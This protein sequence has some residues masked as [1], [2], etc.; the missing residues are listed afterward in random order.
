MKI[1]SVLFIKDLGDSFSSS[2]L[3]SG[4]VIV[5]GV[6]ENDEQEKL[7]SFYA[8]ELSFSSK[9]LV[10]LTADEARDL[11]VKKDTAYLRS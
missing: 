1:K 8:D 2:F 10:G 11:K 7:F 4:E 9:E 6:M 3:S 5:Y